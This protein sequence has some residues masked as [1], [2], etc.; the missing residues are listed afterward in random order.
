MVSNPLHVENVKYT[1]LLN[2]NK[3][4]S[5]FNY[6]VIVLCHYFKYI[7]STHHNV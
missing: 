4:H 5:I 6:F 7:F 3:K 1:R 2:Q